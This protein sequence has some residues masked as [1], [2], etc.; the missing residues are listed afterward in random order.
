MISSGSKGNRA[1]EVERFVSVHC[2]RPSP[3]Q[4]DGDQDRAEQDR[5]V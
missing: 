2:V 5:Q 1:V 3:T 4:D